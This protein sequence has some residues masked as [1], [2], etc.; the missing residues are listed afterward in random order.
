MSFS[1]EIVT[2]FPSLDDRCGKYFRYR[3]LIECGETWRHFKIDNRPQRFETY[4]AMRELCWR[5]LDPLLDRYGVA[6]LHYGFASAALDELVHLKRYPRTLRRLDQHAGCELNREGR[7][8]C[9][10]LGL[11]VDVRI[12]EVSSLVVSRWVSDNTD[13]DRIYFYGSERPF[14]VSVGPENS[15]VVWRSPYS[16]QARKSD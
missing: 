4:A 5:V 2:D 3:D 9:S 6:E 16:R 10:R 14:H 12:P 11:A 1:E 15:K 13:F 8:Y 7:A